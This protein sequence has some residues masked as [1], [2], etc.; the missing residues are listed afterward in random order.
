MLAVAG[1]TAGAAARALAS[2]R[3]VTLDLGAAEAVANRARGAS[4]RSPRA[5]SPSTGA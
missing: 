3:E 5:A 2:G 4:H 1:R